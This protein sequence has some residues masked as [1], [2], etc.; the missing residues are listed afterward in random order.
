MPHACFECPPRPTRST[1][2]A[3]PSVRVTNLP[4][5]SRSIRMTAPIPHVLLA[6]WSNMS[7]P[8][9]SIR[10]PQPSRSVR[11]PAPTL[12]FRTCAP[13]LH[14]SRSIRTPAPSLTFRPRAP[15]PH[16]SRPGHARL[17]TPWGQ[18]R[19]RTILSYTPLPPLPSRLERIASPSLLA[20]PLSAGGWKRLPSTRLDDYP[21][22]RALRL[23]P[24]IRLHR[25][26]MSDQLLIQPA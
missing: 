8:S 6:F 24:Q 7:H 9:R 19:L 2:I 11:I 5:P 17:S 13:I 4:N 15:I 14:P 22:M 18:T 26:S 10:L 3:A 23:T 21:A 16:P 1:R 12:T 20:P 25:T